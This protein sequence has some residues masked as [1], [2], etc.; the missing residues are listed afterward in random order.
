MARARM[1]LRISGRA[2]RNQGCFFAG[3]ENETSSDLDWEDVENYGTDSDVEQFLQNNEV[4]QGY[5]GLQHQTDMGVYRVF[6][7]EQILRVRKGGLREPLN[8]SKISPPGL[9]KSATV[10]GKRNRTSAEGRQKEIF[11][12]KTRAIGESGRN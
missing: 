9:I 5:E 11:R 10:S 7:K 8:N 3:I 12:G 2:G 1:V 6:A 4:T